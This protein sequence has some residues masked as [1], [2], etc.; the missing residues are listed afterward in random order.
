[1][2]KARILFISALI[3][4]FACILLVGCSKTEKISSVELKDTNQD[5]VIETQIGRFDFDAYTL[6]V[7]YDS[8]STKEVTLTEDMI[9]EL[10]RLKLYQAGEHV[11]TVSYGGKTCEVKISV[12]RNVFG[13][14]NFPENNVFTYD[15]K[16]HTVELEGELPANASVSYLGGNSFINAGTYDVT[17]VVSC[18][19]YVTE[20]ITT[21]VTIERA[22]YDM[23][24]VKLESKEVVYDGKA[25]SIEIS[26]QLP[27]GVEAPTYYIDGNKT[28][29]AVD[30]GTYKVT[31]VFSNNNPNYE[32][33][34]TLET[35]LTITP[36]EYKM[37]P[38][39]LVFK[40][41][42]GEEL[43]GPWKNYDGL[44]V[45]FDIANRTELSN[46][47]SFS[48]TVFDADGEVISRSNAQTN[49]KDAGVY[50]IKVDFI[51]YDNK[52]YQPIEPMT[53]KFEVWKAR[54]DT[55]MLFFDSAVTEYDNEKHSLAIT[56]PPD[57]HASRVDVAYEYRLNGK[58]ITEGGK[59]ADGVYAAGEYSV[60]AVFTVRDPNYE[61]I[62]P[63]Q[64]TLVI[65]K[66]KIVHSELGFESAEMTYTGE[67]MMPSLNFAS[68]NLIAIGE[69]TVY[70]LVGEEYVRVDSAI[71]AGTYR[72]EA[73]LNIIDN[74]NYVF[75][76]G[77]SSVSIAGNF[78]IGEAEM[79]ITHMEFTDN[80]P[81]IINRGDDV[82]FEFYVG[83]NIDSLKVE[84]EIDMIDGEYL[85]SIFP[86]HTLTPD[87][88]GM[89]AIL[90]EAPSD[91]PLNKYLLT[92]TVTPE[93]PN[94]AL[95]TDEETAK[96]YYEF[97]IAG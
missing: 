10:D 30:A 94:Y 62:D 23:S 95:G 87:D 2:K 46:H 6:V 7:S 48:Y 41:E 26:G 8:G 5:T 60:T 79:D 97:E 36:A 38:V 37:G 84:A 63:M 11:I 32:T 16:E 12:K 83:N 51:P 50:T 89:V 70:K 31:A 49:I 86:K 3:A 77:G 69:S 68:E 9:S 96:F 33:I 80:N 29:S 54:Y 14:L 76:N 45:I 81:E 73:T 43:Y 13:S 15:G 67:A 78:V 71:D 82:I 56:L 22:K 4:V 90:F 47:I 27:E 59:N 28:T 17:A 44:G 1:M 64:A 65:E 24:N 21:K 66:K 42:D 74:Q 93:D 91:L 61:N 92:V 58:L 72:A 19:G 34:P 39:D 20:R 88:S 55:S 53:C 25:H 18:N 57:L 85:L 40:N 52:N 35:T 75:D